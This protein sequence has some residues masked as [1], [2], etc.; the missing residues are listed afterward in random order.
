MEKGKYSCHE[1]HY[2]SERLKHKLNNIK[3]SRVTVVEAPSG[4]GKTT[5]VRDF[6]K[7]EVKE[8]VP[9]HWFIA[10]E[11]SSSSSYKRLCKEIEKIDSN[12]GGKL[13]KYE[14]LNAAT[15]GDAIAAVNSINC[16][17]EIYFVIDNFQF[18]YNAF[19]SAFVTALLE[20]SAANLHVIVI[21]HMLKRGMITVMS[22]RG[23][24]HINMN[25]LKLS[26]ED[27]KR[28][29]LLYG[30]R[31]TKQES[32]QIERYTEGWIIAVYLQ[33]SNFKETGILS[34][35]VGIIS[36]MENMV[37]DCLTDEQKTF[38]LC[39]SPFDMVTIQQ[40]CDIIG[41]ETLPEYALDAL[42][43]PFIHFNQVEGKY[44]VHSILA[45]LIIQKR[46]ER[47]IEFE[48]KCMVAAGDYFN[49]S[50]MTAE[51]LGFY[52]RVKDYERMLTLN[53]SPLILEDINRVPFAELAVDITH[54][55]PVSTRQN[56]LLAM[57]QISW[58]LCMNGL[59]EDFNILMEEL[60]RF[61]F[62]SEDSILKGEWLLLSAY[63]SFPDLKEMTEI[64]IKSEPF[65]AGK[66]SQVILPDCPWCFGN[67]S[68]FGEF[69]AEPGKADE[70][71]DELEK[72][73][74]I[75]SR[76]TNGHGC[77]ADVLFRAE[78]AYHRGDI[79]ETEI[80]SYKAV[81]LTESSNQSIIQ[82][83]A[84]LYL[85]HASL[86]RKDYSSWQRAID[87]MER[88][89]SHAAHDTFVSRNEL[90][91]VRGVL[92]NELECHDKIAEWLKKTDFDGHRL[93]EPIIANAMFVHLS[94]ILRRGEFSKIIGICQAMLEIISSGHE[95][96][97]AFLL[98]LMA[99]S[100]K[101]MGNSMESE[102]FIYKA[103]DMLLP[104]MLV[105]PLAAYALYLGDP[106]HKMVE[107]KYPEL[108]DKFCF[109][110]ERF[111]V[112]ANILQETINLGDLPSDLTAR[113]FEVAKLAAGGMR[114][115]EIALTLMVSEST[116]RTH[117]RTIFQKLQIDRRAKLAEK[118]Q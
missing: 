88:A 108:L 30:L 70:E 54:N 111:G 25:D 105:F 36:I 109:V 38:L 115:S 59:K 10:A 17:Y 55:C 37:W 101:A 78:L 81:F 65:F 1:L 90:D 117:M 26:A 76:L 58:A 87:S 12:A 75:Y 47:G 86:H 93:L 60:K 103:G 97:K 100:Y 112:G 46:K 3:T 16:P 22:G 27:I 73:I 84:S 45:E 53:L 102:K 9:V 7:D 107:E 77:G 28:Y 72:F 80:L 31:I 98:L 96:Q 61:I 99:I 74:E 52:A 33:L 50:G 34:D 23:I 63:M 49:R 62:D 83:G 32:E 95:F 43:S 35:N 92:L 116:V 44:E 106:V 56:H 41:C 118:L 14:T 19:P 13:L 2:Y 5:A 18:L 82:L 91:I 67:H 20:H 94:F 57:L 104:D 113:E 48:S 4:Y 51:A 24:M 29:Y 21:T 6:L 68:P 40:C 69:H 15:V 110:K 89:V 79:N 114:N 71:A 64:I 39:L 66:H 42:N 11:E 8:G 85:A